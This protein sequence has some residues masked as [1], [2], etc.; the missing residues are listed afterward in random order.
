MA[1]L[2]DEPLEL[3]SDDDVIINI[4]AQVLRSAVVLF[5]TREWRR[6]LKMLINQLICH[7]KTVDEKRDWEKDFF[8]ISINCHLNEWAIESLP[9]LFFVKENGDKVV[10]MIWHFL[11][12]CVPTKGLIMATH[13]SKSEYT[14]LEISK[15]IFFEQYKLPLEDCEKGLLE[16]PIK[17]A[18]ERRTVKM[19]ILNFVVNFP[20]YK[21]YTP[22]IKGVS[23]LLRKLENVENDS[24]KTVKNHYKTLCQ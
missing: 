9:K 7:L 19:F 11:A 14:T 12:L 22:F 24:D 23:E 4:V 2:Q 5:D 16:S 21:K 3:I 10:I 18:S 15:E 13:N 8:D 17:T 6:L 20:D 1:I